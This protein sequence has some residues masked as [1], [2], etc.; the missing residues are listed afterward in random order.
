MSQ[1]H[2]A[3]Y[4]CH[5]L[6]H[7]QGAQRIDLNI[8]LCMVSCNLA[9]YMCILLSIF[10]QCKQLFSSVKWYDCHFQLIMMP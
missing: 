6:H 2:V 8:I 3:M 1:E 7:F 4:F 5:I 10:G 9:I